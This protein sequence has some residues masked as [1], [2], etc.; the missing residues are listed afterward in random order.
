MLQVTLEKVATAVQEQLEKQFKDSKDLTPEAQARLTKVAMQVFREVPIDDYIKAMEP[1]VEK[2]YT[3][4]EL[5]ALVAFY[6]TPTGQS[7][8]KKQPVAAAETLK[9]ITPMIRDIQEEVIRRSKEEMAKIKKEQ[10]DAPK[11]G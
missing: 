8:Q 4:A 11:K 5:R 6:S 3:Q 7:I 10:E 2:T 9:A 1:V